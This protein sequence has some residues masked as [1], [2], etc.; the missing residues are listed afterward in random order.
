MRFFYFFSKFFQFLLTRLMRGVTQ[1]E[2]SETTTE[3]F[4]LTRLMRGVTDLFHRFGHYLL[5][6]THT[7][8]ARRDRAKKL[9][10]KNRIK[11]LLTRLMRG[12][13]DC[14]FQRNGRTGF[15]LTRLMRGVT[16]DVCRIKQKGENFYSHASCEA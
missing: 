8:H 11:F 5:I 4:L 16:L 13:T 15:L 9:K 10:T 2:P 6:S 14:F 1:T 7:P 12:V 3:L